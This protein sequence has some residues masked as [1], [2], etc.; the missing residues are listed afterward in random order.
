MKKTEVQLRWPTSEEAARLL[1]LLGFAEPD[2]KGVLELYPD[3]R[4]PPWWWPLLQ[5]SRLRLVASMGRP[6]K[7]DLLPPNAPE[8]GAIKPFFGIYVL[9]SALPDVLEWH[10]QRCVPPEISWATLADLGRQAGIYRRFHGTSGFDEFD[11][12]SGHF[13]GLIFQIGRLQ[14]ERSVVKDEWLSDPALAAA[15]GASGR[16]LAV[17]IPE[18]GPLSPELCDESLAKAPAF[19]ARH[20]PDE[21]YRAATCDS[22]LLDRQ[23]SEY[24]PP[25]ANIV[26]FQQRFTLLPGPAL[27][28]R[29]V[30]RFVFYK[31][32]AALGELPQRTTLERAVVRHLEHGRD[33]FVR[34]GWLLLEPSGPPPS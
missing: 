5:E 30:L 15:A 22:W 23:L 33:W 28:N 21:E 12:L 20:F 18:E 9:L 29:T 13:R 34:V 26:R 31:N 11:W 10:A 7:V 17:H 4:T 2:L 3:D 14:F 1:T 8:L 6:G 27:G 19:F 32:E 24:L 25:E 16:V